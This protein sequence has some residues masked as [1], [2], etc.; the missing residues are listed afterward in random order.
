MGI[1]KLDLNKVIRGKKRF[2]KFVRFHKLVS[3]F[4]DTFTITNPSFENLSQELIKKLLFI[5][6]IIFKYF[7]YMYPQ[8]SL[9]N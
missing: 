7:V 5:K 9:Q 4:I 6:I 2:E 1:L 8:I 3:V